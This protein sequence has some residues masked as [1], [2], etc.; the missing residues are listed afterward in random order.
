MR[1]NRQLDS[2]D[3]ATYTV[4]LKTEHC[5]QQQATSNVQFSCTQEQLQVFSSN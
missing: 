2:V 5:G 1:Q 4:S 3:E